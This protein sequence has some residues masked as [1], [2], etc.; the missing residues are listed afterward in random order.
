MGIFDRLGDVLRSYLHDD[1]GLFGKTDPR[2]SADADY[3]E[4][5][6]ELNDFLNGHKGEGGASHGGSDASRTSAS[7]RDARPGGASNGDAAPRTPPE[8]LRADFAELDVPFGASAAACKAAYKKLL[9]AHHPDHHAGHA[10][11]LKKATEKSARLN[12]A[13]DR[14]ERWRNGEPL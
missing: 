4:A 3:N 6:D 7:G 8:I 9:K 2:R 12:A 13:W 10:E 14:I 11:S 1:E 5:W